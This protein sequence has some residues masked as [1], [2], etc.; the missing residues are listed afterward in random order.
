MTRTN[1][2]LVAMVISRF[3]EISGFSAFDAKVERLQPNPA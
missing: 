1:Y 3:S 2:H